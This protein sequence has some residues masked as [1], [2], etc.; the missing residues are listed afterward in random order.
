MEVS[1]SVERSGPRREGSVL[2]G[3]RGSGMIIGQYPT[4]MSRTAIIEA[5]GQ[6][7]GKRALREQL[8]S[9]IW[10]RKIQ[11]IQLR[12][13]FRHQQHQRLPNPGRL[14]FA[15]ASDVKHEVRGQLRSSVDEQ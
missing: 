3:S 2:C 7:Q 14:R 9:S 10:R 4:L 11:T 12:D 13:R 5:L 15:A 1:E 8:L 6:L